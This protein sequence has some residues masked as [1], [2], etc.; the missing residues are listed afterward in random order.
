MYNYYRTHEDK[1]IEDE[2]FNEEEYKTQKNK[3]MIYEY[4]YV[5]DNHNERI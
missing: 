3:N 1:Y 2:Y 4:N 5:E